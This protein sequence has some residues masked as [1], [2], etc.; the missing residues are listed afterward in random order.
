M[1]IKKT[2]SALITISTLILT[3]CA[4]CGKSGN[5]AV[6]NKSYES[7]VLKTVS[8]KEVNADDDKTLLFPEIGCGLYA[9]DEWT[10][11]NY[12]GI[13]PTVLDHSFAISYLS[14]AAISEYENMDASTLDDEKILEIFENA[15]K[16]CKIFYVKEGDDEAMK[17]E[18]E[19]Y[20]S[21]DKIVDFKGNT[22]YIAYNTDCPDGL[23]T[24][25]DSVKKNILIFPI[26]QSE[27]GGLKNFDTLSVP[28]TDD[29][30]G[31]PFTADDFKDYDLTMINIWATWCGPCVA[32]L[33]DLEDVYKHL[34]ENVNM[35]TICTDGADELETCNTILKESGATFTTLAGDQ[36]LIESLL[37]G[38]TSFPTTVFVDS[39]GLLVGEPVLGANK[40]AY[41][42]NEI[43]AHLKLLK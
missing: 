14:K 39:N 38:V 3:L 33:P 8:G 22:Y 28:K 23:D 2:I 4:G 9:P 18:S 6:T 24:T 7:D 30:N 26:E 40:A 1:K 20:A 16:F 25:L 29:I 37:S 35:I 13:M 43:D 36:K 11:E 19:G 41:Y 34:P 15:T 12:P 21:T 17:N 42:L 27:D 5:D 31:T 32:E 10:N